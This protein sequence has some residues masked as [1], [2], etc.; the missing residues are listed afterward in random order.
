[1]IKDLF[2][3]EKIDGYYILPQDIVGVVINKTHVRATL[4]VASGN[5]L[6][7][8]EFFEEPLGT[9]ELSYHE[10]VVAALKA[11]FLKI[12]TAVS[13]R[14][15]LSSSLIMFKQLKLPF[16]DPEKIR[17]ILPFEIAPELPFSLETAV[18]DFIV[19]HVDQERKESTIMVAAVQKEHVAQHMAFL[20][21]AGLEP[22]AITVDLFDLYGLYLMIP[23]YKARRG[24]T[25]I[26]DL[27]ASSTRLLYLVDNKLERI[28]TIAQGIAHLA[29]IVGQEL[30]I[31]NGDALEQVMRFGI[32]AH[33]QSNY[34]AAIEQAVASLWSAVQFTLSSF[35]DQTTHKGSVDT[36]LLSGGFSTL[37]GLAEYITKRSS[38]TCM[39]F[40]IQLLFENPHIKSTQKTIVP[41]Q[42]ASISTAL[43]SPITAECNL[44]QEEFAPS[45]MNLLTKQLATAGLLTVLLIA[46]ALTISIW[47]TGKLRQQERQA[48]Q[49]AITHL[50]ELGLVGEDITTLTEA[51][52]EAETKVRN[53][54]A[55]WFPFSRQARTSLLNILQTLS[56]AIDREAIDLQLKRLTI[57]EVYVFIEGSV[58]S[59]EAL[60]IFQ[61]ELDKT[62]LFISIPSFQDTTFSEKLLLKKKKKGAL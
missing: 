28:R 23:A 59:F 20:E 4:V 58:K 21:A 61:A 53:K 7:I 9:N 1:M 10:R 16:T 17:M 26:L 5:S 39:P 47:Q 2:I 27:Q 41:D 12:G 24:V 14:T 29:K 36:I 25:V 44:L 38:I 46:G 52:E 55:Q 51:V 8:K 34:T 15:A 42:I 19:T 6:Q 33:A 35:V 40:D 11:I 3:P 57:T 48:Q 22:A 49:A 31:A 45:T 62:N 60:N 37:P 18:V 54:E 50:Q 13:I 56:S 32:G 43:P 30:H